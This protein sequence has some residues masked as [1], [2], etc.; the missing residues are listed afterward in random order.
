MSDA[1]LDRG[2]VERALG[3]DPEFGEIL[4][5]LRRVRGIRQNALGDAIEVSGAYIS[6]VENGLR[7]PFEDDRVKQLAS[8]LDAEAEPL[9]EAARRSRDRAVI[10]DVPVDRWRLYRE[11]VELLAVLSPSSI[12]KIHRVLIEHREKEKS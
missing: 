1:T 8:A 5:L 4:R 10:G 6:A 9:L 3:A 7:P 2:F 11:F 12:R